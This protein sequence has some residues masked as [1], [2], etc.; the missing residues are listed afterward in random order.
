MIMENEGKRMF[1]T[2]LAES[3]ND[4]RGDASAQKRFILADRICSQ[5]NQNAFDQNETYLVAEILSLLAKDIDIKI[6]KKISESLNNNPQ[7]PREVAKILSRDVLEVSLPILEFSF[8]LTDEDLIE[9]VRSAKEMERVNA[10]A[11][12]Q[13][14]GYSVV[15]E[16][17]KKASELIDLTLLTNKSAYISSKA[18]FKMIEDFKTHENVL[19]TIVNRGGLSLVVVEKMIS[20]VSDKLKNQLIEKYTL[21]PDVLASII[22]ESSENVMLDIVEFDEKRGDANILVEHLFKKGKLNNAIILRSLCKGDLEFFTA[23]LAKLA[24]IPVVNAR[25]L[26]RDESMMGFLALYKASGMQENLFDACKVI[27]KYILDAEKYDDKL[28][29]NPKKIMERILAAGYD[30]SVR[31]MRYI[32]TLIGNTGGSSKPT[33]LN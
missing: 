27:L 13:N 29:H 5:F 20:V 18:Y 21:S 28:E 32:M 24:N 33:Y 16:L 1:V 22:A 26:V 3:L 14:L 19:E 9:I 15:D 7:L 6:R 11:K 30:R 25:K 2:E 4:L 12:R 8:S 10:I 23:S 17:V 31:N